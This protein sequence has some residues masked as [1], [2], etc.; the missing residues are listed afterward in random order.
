[1]STGRIEKG[2][3]GVAE[4]GRWGGFKLGMGDRPS[5]LAETR[6]GENEGQDLP[7]HDLCSDQDRRPSQLEA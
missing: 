3:K 1:M 2:K 6:A 5:G 7:D 4:K